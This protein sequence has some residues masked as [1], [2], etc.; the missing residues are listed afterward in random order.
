MKHSLK[1]IIAFALTLLLVMSLSA[2]AF[3][4]S[5]PIN[6]T[7]GTIYV[8][9]TAPEGQVSEWNIGLA[10]ANKNFTMN[11]S[12]ISIKPGTTGMKLIRFT[13]TANV[14]TYEDDY[15]ES[16]TWENNSYK[17]TDYH[18][19]VIFTKTGTSTI[20]YVVNNKTYKLKVVV[21]PYMNR[22]KTISFTGVNSGKNFASLTKQYRRP[23]K[24]LS[25][26][27]NTKGAKL[28]ITPASGM[29]ITKVEVLDV[30][31]GRYARISYYNGTTSANL[32]W[33]TLN[34]SHN[35]NI[36]VS[37]RNAKEGWTGTLT[38]FVKGANAKA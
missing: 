26:K 20:S 18:I 12:D 31:N 30:N 33:G 3:A 29:L 38:Y 14:N 24:D 7:T 8:H 35:Y 5:N 9:L 37:M 2:P 25:L 6:F 13:K 27:A 28:S 34:A 19:R 36:Y 10:S 17:N 4:A 1:R 23:Q 15:A 32:Y 21:E 16:G 22:V 11:R